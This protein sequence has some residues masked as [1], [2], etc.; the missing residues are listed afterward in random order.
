[1]MNLA[2]GHPV[3]IYGEDNRVDLFESKTQRFLKAAKSTAAMIPLIRLHKE[4][5]QYLIR[6]NSLQENGVCQKERFSHQPK[7]ALCS[8]FLVGP[9]T[10]VT[11]GH[12]IRNESDC[13]IHRWVFDYAVESVSQTTVYVPL[14][15]VYSCQKIVA[16]TFD[17]VTNEDYAVIKLNRQVVDRA[18]LPVRRSGEAEAGTAVLVIGHPS[19]LPTKI[20]DGGWVRSLGELLLKAN[21]DSFAGNSG[22]AV[23]NAQTLEVEGILVGGENDYVL[24]PVLGCKIP[25]YCPENGCRGEDV[26]RITKIKGL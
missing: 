4:G 2:M 16:R 3:V 1:M 15:S 14:A 12:C 25:Q 9:D 6:A 18:P 20:A 5:D 26:M 23:L 22:S 21:V 19:G 13:K 10:L 11:A 24:D 7:A 17:K 8:G